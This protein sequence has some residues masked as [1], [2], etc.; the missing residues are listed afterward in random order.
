[1]KSPR[2]PFD[3]HLSAVSRPD[4]SEDNVPKLPQSSGARKKLAHSTFRIAVYTTPSVSGLKS[5]K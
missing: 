1:M 5:P 3:F 4:R 2:V